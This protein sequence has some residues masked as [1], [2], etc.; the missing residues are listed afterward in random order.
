MRRE[1]GGRLSGGITAALFQKTMVTM[2]IAEL[3]GAATAV[4][5]SVLTGCFLGGEA[6]AAFGIGGPYFS[7]ASIVSGLL[8]VGCTN[9]C[10]RA[11]GK[12]DVR[13]LSDV[14]SLTLTL[15]AVISV[16]LGLSGFL[17]ADGYA[18]LFGAG[19]AGAAVYADTRA[20]LR[21]IFTGA[22]GFIL[23]VILTPILQLDGDSTLPKIASA[24]S[25]FVD[26]AGDLLNIFVFKGG[27]LGMALA[28]TFSHYAAL[29]VTLTHFLKK[30]GMFRFSPEALRP[31]DVPPLLKDGLSR[32]LCMFSRALLPILLNALALRVAG[33][34]GVTALSARTGAS[35]LLGALGWGIGGAVLLMG[36]MMA[37]EQNVSGLRIVVR[38][39]LLDVLAFVTAFAAVVFVIA[40]QIAALYV[41]EP[42]EVR[43]MARTALRC[44]AL[45][46]PF[47]ALNVSASNYFLAVSRSL[48]ANLV[49]VGI[50]V[51]FP[52]ALTWL[53][54][55]VAGTQGL[56]WGFPAGQALL[57]LLL[58]ARFALAK[59]GARSGVQAYMLLP[60][61]FGVPPE[62]CIERSVH[63]LDD[64][65]TL[66]Q[67][68]FGFCAAHGIGRREANRLALC[69][70]ELA[71]NVIEHGFRDGKPHRLDLRVLVK[72]GRVTL[73]MRDDCEL[74]DLKQK[75]ASWAPD[76]EHPEKGIGIRL[77][78]ASASD[79]VYSASMNTNNLIITI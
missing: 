74:F 28:S 6:L 75:A 7:I 45:C 11:V 60:P 46:L 1:S 33:D 66:S 29:A 42:G 26:I 36:G 39:A 2:L 51:V 32:A 53:L 13:A 3:T 14:F 49:N 61:D 47:L 56:W 30:G 73:R 78:M 59:D 40:P 31:R 10:T 58:F 54:C 62:D 5:D 48:A 24:V 9:R 20:Y 4:I 69:I 68:V 8:M 15:G 37:G 63:G 41:P 38:T 79:I 17:F 19:R 67:E 25:A 64:V 23:F 71:G 21:G 65:V 16:L 44:Y 52:A 76:P 22:P 57:S 50:E 12:G 55:R 35:F 70:E 72:E 77:V 27:M 18:R 43:D 34:A